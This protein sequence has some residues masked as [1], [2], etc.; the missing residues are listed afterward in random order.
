MSWDKEWHFFIVCQ[1][2]NIVCSKLFLHHTRDSSRSY[3]KV[4]QLI[5]Y[6]IPFSLSS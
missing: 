1:Y 3:Q 6:A 4:W 5:R 2:A